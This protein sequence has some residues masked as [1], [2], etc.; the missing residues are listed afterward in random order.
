[1]TGTRPV[2]WKSGTQSMNAVCGAP[3]SSTVRRILRFAQVADRHAR[4]ANASSALRTARWVETAPLGRPVVPEVYRIVM[5]SS[6]SMSM[7]GIVAPRGEHVV[8]REDT[9]G[10]SALGTHDDD[11]RVDLA[12]LGRLHPCEPLVVGDDDLRS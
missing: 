9:I 4:A 11:G 2:T 5:S 8:E 10:Q 3:P 6:G 12:W 7:S 1:M